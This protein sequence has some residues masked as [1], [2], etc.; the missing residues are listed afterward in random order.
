[1]KRYILHTVLVVVSLFLFGLS[2]QA[3]AQQVGGGLVYG[4][5]LENLGLKV[6]GVYPIQD[7][8]R[9]AADFTYYFPEDVGPYNIDFYTLNANGHYMFE[10]EDQEFNVYGIAGLNFAIQSIPEQT[11][12]V[13]FGQT[14]TIGGTE[15]A[16]GLNLGGGIEY[17]VDF[18]NI[19]GELKYTISDFDQVVFA[20]GVMIPIGGE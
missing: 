16:L 5:E 6:Q 20:A 8:I 1:M 10:M 9:A 18:G 15:S 17:P 19:F 4:S 13:G 11:I 12:Q 7:Q 14:T 3:K 2:N